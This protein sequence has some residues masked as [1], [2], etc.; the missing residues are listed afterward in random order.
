[1]ADNQSQH[2]SQN[3][4]SSSIILSPY[5][6]IKNMLT[7]PTHQILLD[8]NLIPTIS[9]IFC[10]I[11]E[12]IVLQLIYTG[13]GYDS[14]TAYVFGILIQGIIKYIINS[15]IVGLQMF[16]QQRI[17]AEQYTAANLIFQHSLIISFVL[18]VLL[19]I[20]MWIF[21]SQIQSKLLTSSTSN[22][23]VYVLSGN[24]IL[25]SFS[26]ASFHILHTENATTLK[27][28]IDLCKQIIKLLII[29][30]YLLIIQAYDK[31]RSLELFA[32]S[33]IITNVLFCAISLAFFYEK[34]KSRQ[35]YY[36]IG[37]SYIRSIKF[38]V[39]VKIMSY[40]LKYLLTNSH[41]SIMMILVIVILTQQKE[42]VKESYAL[43]VCL[44]IL[45]QNGCN[46]LSDSLQFSIPNLFQSN[47]QMKRYDRL[48]ALT[49]QNLLSF[50]GIN[51]VVNLIMFFQ[52]YYCFDYIYVGLKYDN[53]SQGFVS[54]EYKTTVFKSISYLA[55]E[56]I[57]RP[58]QTYV[59]S[60][61]PLFKYKDI[62][63]IMN[64][65][66]YA[67]V[68]SIFFSVL[69]DNTN[70]IEYMVAV[71]FAMDICALFCY[72]LIIF[73]MNRNRM[74]ST[75]S[76]QLSGRHHDDQKNK[77]KKEEVE[78]DDDMTIPTLEGFIDI[79]KQTD[80]IPIKMNTF[81]EHL[82]HSSQDKSEFKVAKTDDQ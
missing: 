15:S 68:I 75:E 54:A 80:I 61:T 56:A 78:E 6:N 41:E 32:I 62:Q 66:K 59:F 64:V 48:Q 24:T 25:Y 4:F 22:Y 39:F 52:M 40:Q 13:C 76:E 34:R 1:M 2:Q 3:S 63:I 11:I 79:P 71:N 33:E 42:A 35:T 30:I 26:S 5:D 47:L 44:F 69:S 14:I 82:D 17:L 77:K 46:S 72:V 57:F 18:S 19:S 58:I 10:A 31:T 23:L 50:V 60:V 53:I 21:S 27:A 28:A 67:L 43:A 70:I 37:F 9:N 45:F 74:T 20:F 38:P 55:I 29:Y 51:A 81:M 12:L 65:L 16:I 73:R 7:H 8:S 49:V 36:K